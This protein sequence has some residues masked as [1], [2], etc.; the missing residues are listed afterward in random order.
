M[1]AARRRPHLE[2]LAVWIVNPG[3]L[4]RA[5]GPHVDALGPGQFVGDLP[6]RKQLPVG[7][8]EDIEV[9]V[10]WRFHRHGAQLAAYLQICQLDIHGGVVVPGI[11]GIELIVPAIFPRIRVDRDDRAKKQIV[12]AGRADFSIPGIAVPDA[13]EDLI[14]RGVIGEGVP[15][16]AASPP[17]PPLPGPGLRRHRHGLVL[18]AFGR[19]TG[20][21]V[22]TPQ[23]L[24]RLGIVGR[25]IATCEGEVAAALADDDFAAEG[26]RCGVDELAAAFY[27]ILHAPDQLAGLAVERDQPPVRRADI[28]L[29]VPPAQPVPTPGKAQ[30]QARLFA[31]MRV[32]A[33]EL[34]A[35]RRVDRM[36]DTHPL[37]VIEHAVDLDRLGSR[38]AGRQI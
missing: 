35:A 13:K 9:A 8:V 25:G 14:V 17:F 7:A 38:V 21:R 10:L 28:H 6:D 34:L 3:Y 26:A 5:P 11:A 4:D 36:D 15:G 16:Y 20:Y 33:P 22:E 23:L 24:A 27:C 18:E 31:C 29:A 30:A 37:G 2:S 19:V 1:R 32:V 12:A